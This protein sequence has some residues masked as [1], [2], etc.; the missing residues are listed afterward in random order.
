MCGVGGWHLSPD[1]R[2]QS[3]GDYIQQVDSIWSNA[4][5]GA[6]SKGDKSRLAV[7]DS[8]RAIEIAL[9]EDGID[10]EF[11]FCKMGKFDHVCQVFV[12]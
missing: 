2:P 4:S 1:T 9:A 3:F 12:T 5:S 10:P 6:S 8:L 11:K 7:M